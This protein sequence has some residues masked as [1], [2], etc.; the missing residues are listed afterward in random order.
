MDLQ[1]AVNTLI[2]AANFAQSKGAFSLKDASIIQ[3]AIDFFM[4]P[5]ETEQDASG[6]DPEPDTEDAEHEVVK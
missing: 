4:S 2:G 3:S 5:T 6:E 1:T